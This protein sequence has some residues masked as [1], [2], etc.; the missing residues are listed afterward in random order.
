M[1]GWVGDGLAKVIGFIAFAAVIFLII[2]LFLAPGESGLPTALTTYFMG[3]F[4]R[5]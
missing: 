2:E 1:S 4:S 5:G 3:V